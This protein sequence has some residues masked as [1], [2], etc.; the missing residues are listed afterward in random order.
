MNADGVQ[1]EVLP[2][3]VAVVEFGRGRAN[4]FDAEMIGG[5]ADAM[6]ELDANAD[7]RAI[8]LCSR[9]EHFCAGMDF[10]GAKGEEIPAV[11]AEIYDHAARLFE[12]SLPVVAA[13]QGAAIGGGLGLAMAADFRIGAPS[14]R[15]SAN[16]AALGIHHGFGLSETLPRAV[17]PQI[18][19]DLLLSGRRLDG[20]AAVGLGVLDRISDSQ[21]KLR[22]DA[23]AWARDFARCAPLA[24][25]SI[26]AT[27]RGPALAEAVRVATRR[28]LEQQ[29]PLFLTDD[30]TEGV[31]AASEK[32]VPQFVSH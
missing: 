23:I 4:Y 25:T 3:G 2:D 28:E 15:L 11:V 16:F 12:G 20:E 1:V 31:A 19:G 14:T 24:V 17:G 29:A 21:E 8:V 32:R 6:I 13:V 7:A 5:I 30:F 9:G 10:G 26:R 27:L 22:I 18:A